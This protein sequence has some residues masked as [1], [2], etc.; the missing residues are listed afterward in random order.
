MQ[1]PESDSKDL[2]INERNRFYGLKVILRNWNANFQKYSLE[3][4]ENLFAIQK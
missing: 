1:R 2:N 3:S 4:V